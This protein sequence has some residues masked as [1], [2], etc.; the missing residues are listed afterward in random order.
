LA[1]GISLALAVLTG[2]ARAQEAEASDY[3]V[4][5]AYLYNFAKLAQWPTQSVS[6][7]PSMWVICVVGGDDEFVDV[8][9]KTASGRVIEG[10]PVVV[11]R[12]S[13]TDEMKSCQLLFFRSSER[14]RAHA[15][16]SA[17]G[18][19]SILLV[20]ED[21][22]FLQNGGMINLALEH[23]RIRFEVNRD[24]LDRADI[25]FTPQTLTLAKTGSDSGRANSSTQQSAGF[26]QLKHSEPP[27]YPEIAQRMHLK[28]AVQVEVRVQPD[29]TVKEVRV[30]GGHPLLADAVTR[31]VM[32]WKYE[33]SAKETVE[34]VKYSFGQ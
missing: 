9:R 12:V 26:R 22:S 27:R 11:K 1:V 32:K 3:Q 24:A 33:P 31:A 4:K 28:G 17:L 6:S 16:I 18:R 15:A 23:G 7:G 20:G 21:Q 34:I 10:R 29:G 30:L 2:G 14:K 8:L 5:A 13:A 25:R 19:A